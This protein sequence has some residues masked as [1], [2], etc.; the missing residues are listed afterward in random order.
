M[1]TR[2]FWTLTA[3]R[4]VKTFAQALA[5]VLA[6]S[7]VGLLSADW[8]VAL[9]TAGMA[10]VVSVLTS[11]ASSGVGPANSPSLVP[12]SPEQTA[13]VVPIGQNQEN[14]LGQRAA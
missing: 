6:A 2:Q 9:S 12:T 13:P 1:F 8:K 11:V 14:G 4:A 3:E 10:T 7:G 5:A